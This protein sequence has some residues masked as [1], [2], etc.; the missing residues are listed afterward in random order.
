ML[1]GEI[2]AHRLGDGRVANALSIEAYSQVFTTIPCSPN[3]SVS[4]IESEC[5]EMIIIHTNILTQTQT[6]I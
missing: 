5:F 4:H 1:T 2:I 6:D 3:L